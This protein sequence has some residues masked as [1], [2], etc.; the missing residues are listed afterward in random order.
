[1]R[2]DGPLHIVPFDLFNIGAQF[3]DVDDSLVQNFLQKALSAVHGMVH[4]SATYL[5]R[6]IL[7]FKFF[8]DFILP[9]V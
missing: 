3:T 2:T 1:M 5:D 4:M 8:F 6:D 7:A 9:T